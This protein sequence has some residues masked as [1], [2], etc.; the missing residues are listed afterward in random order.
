MSKASEWADAIARRPFLKLPPEDSSKDP[1]GVEIVAE[2]TDRGR[3]NLRGSVGSP[4]RALALAHWII[5]TFSDAE[6][7]R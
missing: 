4:E 2:V 3:L 1:G 6:P 5:D 7:A